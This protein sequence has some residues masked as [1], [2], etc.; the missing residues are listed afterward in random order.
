MRKEKIKV[1]V[2]RPFEA[3]GHIEE[4]ENTLESFQAIVDGHIEVVG[5]PEGALLVCNEEGKL[6]MLQ[7]NFYTD[8][9]VIVGTVAIVGRD[10]EEFGDC[11]YLL[12]TWRAHLARWGNRV[13]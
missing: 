8:G 3:V 9:D 6:K 10:G 13:W 5:L 7:P 2:K 11:P 1:I 4:V 12:T